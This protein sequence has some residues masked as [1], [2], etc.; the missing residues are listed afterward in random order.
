MINSK[1][2]VTA[3]VAFVLELMIGLAA[4]AQASSGLKVY[5][6]VHGAGAYLGQE[7]S[8]TVNRS[9]DYDQYGDVIVPQADFYGVTI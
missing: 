2:G 7:G 9:Q 6:Y 3:G 1:L 8:V 4:T 5:V